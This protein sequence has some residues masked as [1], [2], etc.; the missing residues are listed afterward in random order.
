MRPWGSGNT[1]SLVIFGA[2]YGR[3]FPQCR[4]QRQRSTRRLQGGL[5]FSEE[6][7][8]AITRAEPHLSFTFENNIV[9]WDEGRLLG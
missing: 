1:D 2:S 8:I 5:A 7:Q 3:S 4:Q 9:Y 6:G